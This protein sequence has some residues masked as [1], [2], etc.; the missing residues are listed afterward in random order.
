MCR[1]DRRFGVTAVLAII[2]LINVDVI[3]GAENALKKD[4]KKVFVSESQ[5]K[6]DVFFEDS[7]QKDVGMER[8]LNV[9]VDGV[10][11]KVDPVQSDPS[12]KWKSGHWTPDSSNSV[13]FTNKQMSR[14][15]TVHDD[16]STSVDGRER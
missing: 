7:A 10:L 9:N 2:S 11:K 14:Q 6:K 12:A 3:F 13:D 5:K 1:V 4:E 16:F 8:K 15:A